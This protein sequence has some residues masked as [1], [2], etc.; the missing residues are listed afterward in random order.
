MTSATSELA[1]TEPSFAVD[2]TTGRIT[3]MTTLDREKTPVYHL[4]MLAVDSRNTSLWSSA[5]VTIYVADK[6]D[7]KPII[8]FPSPSNYTVQV[9]TLH[10]AVVIFFPDNLSPTAV[11]SNCCLTNDVP[12]FLR[13]S[14]RSLRRS[15]KLFFF[16]ELQYDDVLARAFLDVFL[17]IVR[18]KTLRLLLL[19]F[20]TLGRYV[21]EGV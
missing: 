7:N 2:Q 1:V 9:Y 10:S 6:N 19:L 13:S 21:P 20:F 11:S 5:N 16:K 18:F 3:T 4:V 14:D 8:A 12:A 17:L 15:L